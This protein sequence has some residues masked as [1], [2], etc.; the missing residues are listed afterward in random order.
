MNNY[1]T[2]Q[3]TREGS[4]FGLALL[5]SNGDIETVLVD[6]LPTTKAVTKWH[7][8]FVAD[9]RGL[10]NR[11]MVLS[12]EEGEDEETEEEA[13]TEESDEASGD[14]EENATDSEQEEDDEDDDEEDDEEVYYG[15]LTVSDLRGLCEE[16][17]LAKGGTKPELI[18]RLE[19]DD[20]GDGEE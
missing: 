9:M 3:I 15:D 11:V 4:T 19:N 2:P 13:V 17:G 1:Y 7:A 10:S 18:N 6:G 8:E 16:R 14:S 12:E 5:D 20:E